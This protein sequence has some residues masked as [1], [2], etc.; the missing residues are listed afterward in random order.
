MIKPFYRKIIKIF[1]IIIIILSAVIIVAGLYINYFYKDKAVSLIVSELNNYLKTEV[2]VKKVDFSVFSHFPEASVIFY[3]V[4][5]KSKN[6]NKSGIPNYSDT[7]L[8]AK[9]IAMGF[10]ILDLLKKK[11]VLKKTYINN[12]NLNLYIDKTGD[13][14]FDI[15]KTD[16][17]TKEQSNFKLNLSGIEIKNIDLDF[18]NFSKKEHLTS[19]IKKLHLKGNLINDNFN[20]TIKSKFFLNNYSIEHISFIRKKN[21]YVELKINKKQDN[22]LIDVGNLKVEDVNLNMNGAINISKKNSSLDILVTSKGEKV[23]TLLSL[24]PET[25]KK[26]VKDYRLSGKASFETSIK[27]V[28]DYKKSPHIEGHFLLNNATVKYMPEN[29]QLDSVFVSASFSNGK[30]NSMKTSNIEINNAVAQIGNSIIKGRYGIKNFVSPQYYGMAYVNIDLQEVYPFLKTDTLEDLLGKIKGNIRIKGTKKIKNITDLYTEGDLVASGIGVKFTSD[31]NFLVKNLD[32]K[33]KF[34]N[35]RIDIASLTTKYKH[36]QISLSGVMYDFLNTIS[37]KKVPIKAVVKLNSPK[38]NLDDFFAKHT[39]S[40][41]T[42]NVKY[43]IKFNVAV[44]T[45][46]YHNN[47][48]NNLLANGVISNKKIDLYD[49]K[50]NIANGKLTGKTRY[51]NNKILGNLSATNIDINKLFKIFDNFGQSFI[52]YDN[53]KG[54]LSTNADFSFRLDNSGKIID[55]SL[56]CDAN[57]TI[58]NGELINFEPLKNLSKFLSVEEIRHIYFSDIQNTIYIKNKQITVPQMHI[59]TSTLDFDISG[60]HYFNGDYRYHLQL[61]LSQLLSKKY[62]NNL[63]KENNSFV[64]YNETSSGTKVFLLLESNHGHSHISYDKEKVKQHISDRIKEEKNTFKQMIKEEFYWF[65]KD[66]AI[67]N[68]KKK[69]L[70]LKKKEKK[71]ENSGFQFDFG[72]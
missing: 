1:T 22:Y 47:I 69:K 38:V 63:K 23:N 6:I 56:I 2:Q 70:Q 32:A 71:E 8:S 44:D 43:D 18:F 65:T 51:S 14:N 36:T 33:F 42:A 72:G 9:S 54:I 13:I 10:D 11:Y 66:S 68:K 49:L 46:V 67:K 41:D 57:M 3:G 15:I 16:T 29:V 39:N 48:M 21:M 31:S 19:N 55:S 35:N 17:S 30:E 59:K 26:Y 58:K 60:V 4:V 28:I 45:L 7:L 24:L 53:I 25:Y 37:G 40:Q 52:A 62:R 34:N 20:F 61:L 27:G 64:S 50:V 5:I 12:G